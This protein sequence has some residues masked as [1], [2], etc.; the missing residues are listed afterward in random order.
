M[1]CWFKSWIHSSNCTVAS[2]IDVIWRSNVC[3]QFRRLIYVLEAT[4]FVRRYRSHEMSHRVSHFKILD[5]LVNLVI[6]IIQSL[7][8]HGRTG[9]SNVV[10]DAFGTVGWGDLD[11]QVDSHDHTSR[12]FH[13]KVARASRHLVNKL[14]HYERW[15]LRELLYSLVRIISNSCR[16]ASKTLHHSN[17]P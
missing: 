7:S 10:Q 6:K 13:I 17:G 14:I 9:W 5:V 8:R 1:M 3:Q 11:C 2:G 15:K 4:W 12:I 16:F